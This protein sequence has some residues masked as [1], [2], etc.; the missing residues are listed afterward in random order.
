MD[1]ALGHNHA[2]AVS[3]FSED[4]QIA[5]HE[6]YDPQSL[7]TD[8][9]PRRAS[10]PRRHTKPQPGQRADA[11]TSGRRTWSSGLRRLRAHQ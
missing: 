8:A 11:S 4:R 5:R 7:P 2:R 6:A 9:P 10:F 3:L 1:L